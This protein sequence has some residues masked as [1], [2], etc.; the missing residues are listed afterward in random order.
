MPTIGEKRLC[1]KAK[2][3]NISMYLDILDERQG[4][5]IIAKEL[6]LCCDVMWYDNMHKHQIDVFCNDTINCCIDTGVDTIPLR[7]LSYYW[8][9]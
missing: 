3:D 9:E 4:D 5:I 6:L 8:L 2:K 1:Y 7:K